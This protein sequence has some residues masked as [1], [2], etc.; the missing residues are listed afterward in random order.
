MN[1]SPA[2]MSSIE[3]TSTS[4]PW[5]AV[6]ALASLGGT[7]LTL[8]AIVVAV[9]T[10]RHENRGLQRTLASQTYHGLVSHFNEF[11]RMLVENPR[12]RRNLFER[13]PERLTDAERHQ[14]NWT[15][16]ILFNWYEDA[17]LQSETWR[18]IPDDLAE[19]WRGMLATEMRSP[20]ISNYW[21]RYGDRFHPRL[22]SWVE[23]ARAPHAR[24]GSA[25]APSI[26]RTP[27]GWR[28]WRR[29]RGRRQR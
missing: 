10:L 5:D 24:A 2:P 23:D 28:R 6:S 18:V 7:A 4:V 14:V 1:A 20:A 15:L 3:S 21:D 9:L 19:H 22:R 17:A 29:G 25:I 27:R 11:Q 16:G 13:A 8:I 12:L 26:R